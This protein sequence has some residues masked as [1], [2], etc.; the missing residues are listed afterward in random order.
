[1]NLL[2]RNVKKISALLAIAIT[3]TAVF[4][5]F[6]KKESEQQ[7][8]TLHSELDLLTNSLSMQMAQEIGFLELTA[9]K[10]NRSLMAPEKEALLRSQLKFVINRETYQYGVMITPDRVIN[11]VERINPLALANTGKKR[12]GDRVFLSNP[13]INLDKLTASIPIYQPLSEPKL[14]VNGIIYREVEVNYLMQNVSR[15]YQG[16]KGISFLL[17]DEK[18]V[19]SLLASDPFIEK[20]T[21][22]LLEKQLEKLIGQDYVVR[23]NEAFI[24]A[25]RIGTSEWHLVYIEPFMNQINTVVLMGLLLIIP[26]LV[27]LV[28][29]FIEDKK[30][31]KQRSE[32]ERLLKQEEAMLESPDNLLLASMKLEA[33][34]IEWLRSQERKYAHA[35]LVYKLEVLLSRLLDRESF[36]RTI[37][38][39]ELNEWLTEIVPKDGK[40]T[41]VCATGAERMHLNPAMVYEL[42]NLYEHLLSRD[43]L[44]QIEIA[45]DVSNQMLVLTLYADKVL[46][47]NSLEAYLNERA[48]AVY[49]D[50]LQ[51]S[52][53]GNRI[54]Y[55]LESFQA[56]TDM[57]KNV[58]VENMA[59][60]Q[61]VILFTTDREGHAIIKFYLDY[62]GVK[63][64]TVEDDKLLADTDIIMAAPMGMARLLEL[65]PEK[66]GCLIL[67]KD[68]T[69]D[70]MHLESSCDFVIHRPYSLDKIQQILY[71]VQRK[72]TMR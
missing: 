19:I 35:V 45:P 8:S 59:L 10:L 48:L 61:E 14:G 72:R 57:S 2:R 16:R 33:L 41:V 56:V 1:M 66:H 22:D 30:A 25:K 18:Q 51:R 47:A 20:L 60:P 42:I 67:C 38:L 11:G 53:I 13:I 68:E 4:V 26:I 5:M 71:S 27:I 15:L 52:F 29:I 3:L 17:S 9:E 34:Q 37:S 7:Y 50:Q 6:I 28:W 70:H 64:M 49:K 12:Y 63:Y 23:D 55:K 58:V 36:M 54:I 24:Y 44:K 39:K 40:L 31:L 43:D 46:S 62:L 69:E 65:K 32:L 21:G